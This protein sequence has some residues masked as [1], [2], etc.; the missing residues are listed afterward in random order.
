METSLLQCPKVVFFSPSLVSTTLQ[1]SLQKSLG[2]HSQ[3]YRVL[4]IGLNFFI[5][6]FDEKIND[7]VDQN[8]MATGTV[9]PIKI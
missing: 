9:E 5:F 1:Y 4:A 6:F 3:W 2:F 8:S 7:R